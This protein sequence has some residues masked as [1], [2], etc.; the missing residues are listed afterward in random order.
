[1]NESIVKKIQKL[2]GNTDAVRD[3]KNFAEN[4]QSIRFHH[5]LYDKDWGVYGLDQYY[6]KNKTLYH[7]NTENFIKIYWNIIFVNMNCRTVNIFS[8][9]GFSHRLKKAQTIMENLKGL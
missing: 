2:G 3:D 9:I 8:E 7:D 1:M 5:Y 4:W 6:E